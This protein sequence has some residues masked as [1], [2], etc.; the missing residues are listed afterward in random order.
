MPAAEP[1]DPVLDAIERAIKAEKNQY[2]TTMEVVRQ[3]LSALGLNRE[4]Q[5]AEIIR[6]TRAR[7]IGLAPVANQKIMT[8]SERAARIKFGEDLNGLVMMG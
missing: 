7:K 3:K 6:L 2:V 4:Q 1:A 8:D 5:D